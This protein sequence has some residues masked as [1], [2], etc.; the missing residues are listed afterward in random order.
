[1]GN[2]SPFINNIITTAQI[3]NVKANGN[4]FFIFRPL[5]DF[6][7]SLLIPIGLV[8]CIW[9]SFRRKTINYIFILFWFLASLLPAVASSPNG[10]RAIQTI[11]TVYLFCAIG[12]ISI[13]SIINYIFRVRKKIHLL[14]ITIF[15][16]FSTYVTYFLYL[17]PNRLELPGFYP[18]T[19]STSNY[20]KKIWN[21]YDI[22]I[23]DNY[24]RELLT[25]YLYKNS[26]SD[27]F[28]KSYSWL[29]NSSDFLVIDTKNNKGS[30]FFMFNN[31]QNDIVANNLLS[32]F[33]TS[34]KIIL[35]YD[36][37]NIHRQASLVI[38]VPPG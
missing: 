11:P 29:E 18:E 35:W 10:N 30:A 7:V 2:L 4:D 13:T 25:Y 21:D 9:Y 22:Y 16:V 15:L 6:P 34:K 38:L 5:V 27:A 32:N 19:L 24:P 17:G 3:F 26:S 28:L 12:L 31:E 8:M 1:V 23:T 20:I 36:N 14:L 37:D 33:P